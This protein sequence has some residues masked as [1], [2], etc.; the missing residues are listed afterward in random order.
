MHT[1][2]LI[3]TSSPYLLQ[4]AHNPVQ[5]QPWSE[6]ALQQAQ[7]ANKLMVIS[8]GY[9]ACHWCHVMERESFENDTVAELMNAHYI[10]IKIDREEHPDLDHFYMSAVQMMSGQGGW[11]LNVI[12]LPD[13]RPVWGGTYL[14]RDRWM[15]VL[16]KVNDL[17]QREPER[18]IEYANLLEQGL[19][20]SELLPPPPADPW[21]RAT[22]LPW[23]Q[24]VQERFDTVRGG[25]NRAPKFP[26]PAL[27]AWYLH[28]GHALG[29][30]VLAQQAHRTLE[31]MAYSGLRDQIGGGFFR[32]SVD[33]DWKIPHFEKMLYDNGQLLEVYAQAYRMQ[34]NPLYR[35]VCQEMAQFFSTDLTSPQKALFSALDADSEG[36]EGK[37]Y[38]FSPEEIQQILPQQHRE[39]IEYLGIGS[40]GLWEHGLSHPQ[41]KMS[42]AAFEETQHA[43]GFAQQWPGMRLSLWTARNLRT[44][45][46]TDTKQLMAW[47]A[48]A[49]SGL[50]EAYRAFGDD[51][52]RAKAV[53]LARASLTLFWTP[54]GEPA[55]QWSGGQQE[56]TALA[57]DHAFMIK[58]LLDVHEITGDE[59]WYRQARNL[60][61][62][63]I[64]V[65]SEPDGPL[66][67][68]APRAATRARL[69]QAEVEDNVIPSANAQMAHN[70][71]LMGLLEGNTAWLDRSREMYLAIAGKIER[72]PEGYYHWLTLATT[73]AHPTAEWIIVGPDAEALY[74]QALP[75]LAPGTP[76]RWSDKPSDL[77]CFKHRFTAGKTAIF[78][79]FEGACHMPVY[80]VAEALKTAAHE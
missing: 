61:L 66:F 62:R 14:P 69:P 22:L 38:L 37:Y 52:W 73:W 6:G 64:D 41:A 70:L 8:I 31:N 36:M 80:S 11:P 54:E 35:E 47:N 32:Y 26:M 24:Q 19:T 53:A 30:V 77:P 40:H 55:H 57:D 68:M 58:A 63:A 25:P 42:P 7:S 27:L 65:F 72:Y 21:S 49:I 34:P 60:T 44:K 74:Q 59:S 79:C 28:A 71:Y 9:S 46:G 76:V 51:M 78:V 29:E 50:T 45:P 10:N 20:E 5:W 33:A 3:H 23:C 48:M 1:N 56:H 4:H 16:S 67:Y 75:Y 13:G 43:L 15:E 2:Q 39:V 18:V 12:A 17:Y